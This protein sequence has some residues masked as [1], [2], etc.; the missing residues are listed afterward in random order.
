MIGNACSTN[1]FQL[2][3]CLGEALVRAEGKGALGYI[4]CTDESY[5]DEDYYW[6]VGI[7]PIKANPTYEET[8]LGM[9][10]RAFHDNG[11]PETDWYTT[12]GQMMYAGNLAVTESNSIRS[13]YYWEI[14]TL[15]GDPSLMVYFSVPDPM[16]VTVPDILPVGIY[17]L[18]FQC[19]QNAY[20]ALS[21][22]GKLLDATYTLSLIHI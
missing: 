4:G 13:K 17:N 15:L 6:A 18:H 11:E 5:W 20:A 12:Q 14:Y 10:D 16:V 3:E 2:G 21:I 9:Y 19:E 1:A 8:G 7:G 22:D